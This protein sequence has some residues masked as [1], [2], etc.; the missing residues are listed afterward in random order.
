MLPTAESVAKEICRTTSG[1]A[2]RHKVLKLYG[3]PYADNRVD[4]NTD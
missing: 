2:F 3:T 4:A 1:A